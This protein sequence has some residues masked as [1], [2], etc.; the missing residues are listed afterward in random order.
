MPRLH[1]KQYPQKIILESLIVYYTGETRDRTSAIIKERFGIAVPARTLSSWLAEFR[2]LTGY[3]RLRR[4]ALTLYRPAQLIRTVRLHHKQVYKYCVHRAKLAWILS[5]DEYEHVRSL[6]PYLAAM[7]TDCPHSLFMA[8]GRASQGKAPFDL[9]AVAIA[10]KH[11]HAC[12]LANLMLQTV[13]VNT[14]RHDELQRFMLHVDSATVAVEVPISLT[15]DD[16]RHFR[17]EAGFD[18]PLADAETLTG[19]IDIV[20]LRG[21]RSISS[22]TSP[23][24]PRKSRSSS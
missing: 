10:A 21:G 3:E 8:E 23:R 7:T 11:N 17:E 15:P 19:H 16:I 5:H 20:Q 4:V 1:G 2:E 24:P 9:D 22:T 14:R 13:T 6:G 18:V 12:R